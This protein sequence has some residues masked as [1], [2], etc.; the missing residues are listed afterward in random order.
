MVLLRPERNWADDV[1]RI[2]L[3]KSKRYVQSNCLNVSCRR[4][5]RR[6][7]ERMVS[8]TVQRN[9][10][11]MKSNLTRSLHSWLV[12]LHKEITTARPEFNVVD[13]GERVARIC[14]ELQQMALRSG[15]VPRSSQCGLPLPQSIGESAEPKSR[16]ACD[17]RTRR[18]ARA[19]RWST[20]SGRPSRSTSRRRLA[21]MLETEEAAFRPSLTWETEDSLHRFPTASIAGT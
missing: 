8:I 5:M 17:L 1:L 2:R 4:L 21:S 11:N 19:P 7:G 12:G 20:Y 15:S 14:L 18:A 6:G 13:L 9:P 3:R 10:Q 16:T